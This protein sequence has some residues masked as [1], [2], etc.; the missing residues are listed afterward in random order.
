[1]PWT[2]ARTFQSAA[3][4][5][6]ERRMIISRP[7]GTGGRALLRTGKSALRRTPGTAGCFTERVL[8]TATPQAPQR[9]H[10]P[11]ATAHGVGRSQVC[12]LH[13]L[14]FSLVVELPPRLRAARP[15]DRS[16]T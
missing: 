8:V 1:M 7:D 12:V 13:L 6:A 11:A 4:F 9:L 5:D 14:R 2:G 16:D 10:C 3:L 15:P